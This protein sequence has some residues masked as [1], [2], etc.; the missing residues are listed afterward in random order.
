ML[1]YV[2]I[3]Q[4]VT[5]LTNQRA[6]RWVSPDR[7]GLP[8]IAGISVIGQ[9]IYRVVRTGSREEAAAQAFYAA[10]G[11]RWS[12]IFTCAV[13][14]G[15]RSLSGRAMVLDAEGYERVHSLQELVDLEGERE[16]GK[17]RVLY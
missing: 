14:G 7:H 11:N 5:G 17:I 6:G 8:D 13:V 16:G 10:A 12:T 1:I 3:Q 15:K 9:D 4:S 2:S